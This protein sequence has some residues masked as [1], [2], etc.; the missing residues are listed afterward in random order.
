MQS[1]I[2]YISGGNKKSL[3]VE[4]KSQD[5]LFLKLDT[6]FTIHRRG[7]YNYVQ[8]KDLLRAIVREV[9][10]STLYSK[11]LDKKTEVAQI[12]IDKFNEKFCCDGTRLAKFELVQI[13]RQ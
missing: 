5:A 3:F 7:A 13:T 2:S 1:I 6:S 10:A 8:I 12:I 4:I 11:L 9:L